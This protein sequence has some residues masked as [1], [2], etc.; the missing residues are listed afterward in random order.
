VHQAVLRALAQTGGP[1]ETPLLEDAAAPFDAARA[2]AELA[3]GDF[4]CLGDAGR[5]TAAYPFSALPTAHRVQIAGGASAYAM[6]AIDALGIAPMLGG[7]AVIQ[8]ADS[9]T[10]QPV[11]VTVDG[12][13]SRWHPSTA[14][15]FVGRAGSEN[16]GPSAAICCGYTNFF[17][18][19]AAA[20]AWAHAH[21]EMTGGILSQDR[22]IEAGKQ[23][24][25]RLLR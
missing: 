12:S 6:C 10:G 2:L 25:G 20:A 9:S 21:P 11:T 3:D 13:N 4:L 23:I 17:A 24:F 14:I 1:P 15:V 8:S 5:I 18:T 7:K 16:A 22:A 19:R